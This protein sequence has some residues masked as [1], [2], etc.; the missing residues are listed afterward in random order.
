[1]SEIAWYWTRFH[2]Y[3][4]DTSTWPHITYP[5]HIHVSVSDT[6]IHL[7]AFNFCKNLTYPRIRIGPILIRLS[8]S[9]LHRISL[10]RIVF[11]RVKTPLQ[12]EK[13]HSNFCAICAVDLLSCSEGLLLLQ[14]TLPVAFISVK[15]RPTSRIHLQ[16]GNCSFNYS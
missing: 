2:L 14:A 12:F 13:H 8:V 4:P 5:I 16:L 1:M 15:K 6:P 3:N 10:L 7:C 11:H 9:V